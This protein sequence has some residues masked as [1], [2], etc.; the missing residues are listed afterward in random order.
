MSSHQIKLN[1]NKYL[2]SY[3]N[4]N[5]YIDFYFKFIQFCFCLYNL[6]IFLFV[7]LR[8]LSVIKN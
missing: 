8:S 1:Y 2:Q 3:F 4:P 7:V 6:E 5:N